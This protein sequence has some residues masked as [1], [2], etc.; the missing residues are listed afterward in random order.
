[1]AHRPRAVVGM[2]IGFFVQQTVVQGVLWGLFVD[3]VGNY[4]GQ[5]H[6]PN[7]LP[8]MQGTLGLIVLTLS[9]MKFHLVRGLL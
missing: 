9:V 8:L 4:V 1:M 7:F 5:D 2:A 6:W 3:L